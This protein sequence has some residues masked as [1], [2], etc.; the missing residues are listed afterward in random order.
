MQVYSSPV[1][2]IE[3][4][5]VLELNASCDVR[6]IRMRKGPHNKGCDRPLA[7]PVIRRFEH[8]IV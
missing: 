8:N 4:T 3:S 7:M 6:Q 2:V 1:H 5:L